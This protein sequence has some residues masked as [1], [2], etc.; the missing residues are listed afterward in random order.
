M[1]CYESI[2]EEEF[3]LS[4]EMYLGQMEIWL[5]KERLDLE[6]WRK[7][8]N[9]IFEKFNIIQIRILEIWVRC[10]KQRIV[11]LLVFFSVGWLM[12][13]IDK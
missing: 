2:V 13:S 9:V 1:N 12:E 5:I 7:D 3:I 11:C 8:G 4:V 6:M 10:W